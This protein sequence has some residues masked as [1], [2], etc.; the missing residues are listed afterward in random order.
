MTSPGRTV[1]AAERHLARDAIVRNLP[2]AAGVSVLTLSAVVLLGWAL[3]VRAMQS[4]YPGFVT[5]KANTA[6]GL[7][8]A[9]I[10]LTS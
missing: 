9:A 5:M 7:G 2:R 8:V 4:L 3:D 1:T 6:A 10:A